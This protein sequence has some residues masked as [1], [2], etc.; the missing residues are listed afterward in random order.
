MRRP[1]IAIAMA[2]MLVLTACGDDGAETTE[3]TSP[4]TTESP[5]ESTT[6]TTAAPSGGTF[7]IGQVAFPQNLYGGVQSGLATGVPSTKIFASPVRFSDSFEPLPY[8]AET[9]TWTEDGL[10]L[11]LNLAQDATF[12]DG[13]PVT[14]AD[15]SFSIDV[16]KE[17]HPFG[18]Q[19]WGRL[20]SIDTPDDHTVV[21]NFDSPSPAVMIGL[22]PGLLPVLPEHVYGA[23]EDLRADPGLTT[24]A[25]V[26]SGPYTVS[27]FEAGQ[28][29]VL[30]GR[31]DFFM[32][33]MPFLDTVIIQYFNDPTSTL[34]ALEN[35]D[36]DMIGGDADPILL[37]RA[38]DHPDLVVADQGYEALGSLVLLEFNTL[39]APL[40]IIEV[41]QALAYASDVDFFIN[42]LQGGFSNRQPSP[43]ANGSPYQKPGLPTYDYDLD[44]ARRLLDAAGFPADADGN[45][46]GV[47]IIF[48]PGLDAYAGNVALALKSQWAEVGVDVTVV[49]PPDSPTW[50]AE[51]SSYDYDI[52]ITS[53]WNWGDPAIG[54]ARSYV[55]TNIRE[56]VPFSNVSQYC[57]EDVDALFD[58]GSR[59]PDQAERAR[60]YFEVQDILTLELP[61]YVMTNYPITNLYSNMVSNPPNGIWG[62]MD[63]LLETSVNR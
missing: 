28:K 7:V 27:E 5:S 43:I 40:D 2:F 18:Q 1:L 58:Q 19:I 46:F 41:R 36:I 57:N 16:V 53:L 4:A 20:T 32:E 50:L 33:G 48:A 26:G 14:S 12:S 23:S 17:N 38:D 3:A 52:N 29:I 47:E 54:V 30:Q 15:V 49:S 34:V 8:L 62:A 44:E 63:P 51:V 25:V 9:W 45:R 39:K 61:V 55:C 24:A 10:A 6:A 37:A 21:L 60:L 56:G 13:A 42:E 31:D 59:E 35:G 22:S 11:T